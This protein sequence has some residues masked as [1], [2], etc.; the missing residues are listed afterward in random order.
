MTVRKY[1]PEDLDQILSWLPQ[2]QGS[3]FNWSHATLESELKF[4]EAWILADQ[5]G[6]VCA[7]VCERFL[8]DFVEWTVLAVAPGQQGMGKM[9]RLLNDRITAL[10]AAKSTEKILLEVHAGN[11]GA[12]K[13][14]ENLGFQKTGS[15]ARYYSDG[16]DALIF[17]LKI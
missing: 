6:K 7:F 4:A 13:L 16:S 15:R 14:Y 8:P 2:L 10:R 5:S 1:K 17:S 9:K 11:L 12:V 3:A